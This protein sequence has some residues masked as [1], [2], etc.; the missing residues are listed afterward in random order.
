MD[1]HQIVFLVIIATLFGLVGYRAERNGSILLIGIP[2]TILTF[3]WVLSV[4]VLVIFWCAQLP[5]GALFC[6]FVNILSAVLAPFWL[7]RRAAIARLF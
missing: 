4:A 5:I 6:N 2:M 3:F 7:G 1:I